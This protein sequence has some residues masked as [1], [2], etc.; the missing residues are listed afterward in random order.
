MYALYA[1]VR[2]PGFF[3]AHLAMSPSYG[4]DD[5]FVAEVERVLAGRERLDAFAY[6]STG[7]EEADISVGAVRL[8]KAL[9]TSAP[10][11][12]TSRFEFFPG[13][14]HGSVVH[15]AVYRG[16]E[17]LGF[18][19]AVPQ[20]G[21]V[22]FLG[23]AEAKRRAWTTRFG[24]DTVAPR[25]PAARPSVAAYLLDLLERGGRTPLRQGFDGLATAEAASFRFDDVEL[26]NLAAWL[27]SA[28]RGEDAAAVE[29][30]RTKPAA[31]AAL[32]EYGAA[33]DLARGLVAR[34]ALDGDAVD[35]TG[36]APAGTLA[37]AVAVE[38]RAGRAAHALRFDGSKAR[39]EIPNDPRLN[40]GGS[41]T[42]AAWI[43]PT[44]LNAYAAWISKTGPAWGSEW[45]IG[46]SSKPDQ[47]WGLTVFTDR[48]RDYWGATAQPAVGRWTHVAVVA[49]QTTGRLQYFVDGAAAGASAG[50]VPFLPGTGP[51]YIGFQR[52]DGAYFAGDV[53]DVRIWNRALG[54]A[55]VT[56]VFK[57]FL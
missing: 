16:L 52:D 3:Q 30:L 36:T 5:G 50:L 38:D 42:V 13:E 35:A 2:R 11:G 34:Y 45:R 53:D 48:W 1:L 8:A 4:Q 31:G 9:E 25:G 27:R 41:I 18:A 54:A 51:T 37:G 12:L 56:A 21:A 14:S 10:P 22:R 32:N 40:G 28:G 49:D 19:D 44:A 20:Q 57:D 46:F 29:A 23:D 55:E 15:K 24:A 26:A 33:V 43:R 6:V 17:L 39:V 7:D 47:Q